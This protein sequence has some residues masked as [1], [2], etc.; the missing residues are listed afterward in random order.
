MDRDL[1][2]DRRWVILPVLCLSILIVVV[3]NTVVNVALP[4]LSRELHATTTQLQWIVDA[5]SLVFAGLLIAAGNLGDRLGRKRMLEI[6]LLWFG[7]MSAAAAVAPS[8][9]LL[10]AA[11]AA[12]GVGAAL[13]FPATLA[14]LTNV[15]TDPTERGR[16]IGIWAA[17]TGLAVAIGPVTGGL[18][19]QHFWWGS[20]FFVNVPIVVTAI[21]LGRVFVPDSRDHR[22]GRFDPVA[23]VL[24]VAGVGLL[25]WTVIDAPRRGWTATT[26]LAGF[27]G[28]A[29]LLT[30]F[31]AWEHR[32]EDPMLEVGIFSNMRFT[33]AS[34][35]ITVAYFALY[36]FIFVLTQYFQFVRG[37]SALGTGLRELPFA[38]T[39]GLSAPVAPRLAE[40]FGTKVVVAGGLAAMAGGF[41]IA[42][43]FDVGSAYWGPVVGSM[44]LLAIGLTMTT[45][46]ATE[47]IMGSLPLA[48]AGAGSAVNDTTRQLGGT[49]GVA[50]L[51]SVFSSAYG[52]HLASR[53]EGVGVAPGA[54]HAAR[55]SVAS[56]L[57]AAAHAPGAAGIA[58]ADAARD[59]FMSGFGAA[60]VVAVVATAIGIVLTIRYLPARASRPAD[61]TVVESAPLAVEGETAA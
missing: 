35:S 9:P 51:G 56:A 1:V 46:P 50:A 59:A 34:V 25:V 39:A 2:H 40:R 36:G 16:A 32:R 31:V 18:L 24:S 19:L 57:A 22:A 37:Y 13:V 20:V 6:G 7:A 15:F 49:L 14:I 42:A 30:L 58:I 12:M 47:S 10:I 29:A 55:E 45:A 27:A 4:S 33:A 60:S 43:T 38:I 54:L 21:V 52:T 41:G 23:L 44:I 61:V 8:A 17:V 48:K 26:S 53:L 5:Y 11:R 3:D 28:A